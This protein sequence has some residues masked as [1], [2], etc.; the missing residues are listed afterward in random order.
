MSQNVLPT[1]ETKWNSGQKYVAATGFLSL[2][3]LV[4]I[5]FYGLPF[6][7]DF[8]VQEYGWTRAEV[9]SGN[10][11]GKILQQSQSAIPAALEASHLQSAI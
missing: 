9:T 7:Y 3:S 10:A 11:V 6:F 8:W 1:T 2:F 5:M 4:G